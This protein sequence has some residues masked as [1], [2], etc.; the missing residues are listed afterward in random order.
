MQLIDLSQT[1]KSGMPLFGPNVP[2][3]TITPWMSHAQAA[4]SGNY[5]GC[6]CEVTEVKF[7]TS[8]STYL[9]SPY[10]FHPGGASIDQ[11]QLDQLVLPGVVI[12]C[13]SAQARQPI[14][15]TVLDG[16]DVA[17]KAVLF[18]TGWSHRWGRPEY[19][20][21]PFLAAETAVALRERGAKLAGADFLVIDD[22]TNPKRPV[23]VTLLNANI[24]IVE[25]L[26]NLEKLPQTGFTFHAVPVKVAGAAAFPVRAY[27]VVTP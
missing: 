3:P 26:T 7:I 6:T 13:K 15:P 18:H 1:I 27:A 23:H 9:D 8:L 17:G 25:N 21:Y 11:L 22:T 5:Q 4:A 24:L 14:G 16:I 19:L 2:Q 12:E 10:H 20:S